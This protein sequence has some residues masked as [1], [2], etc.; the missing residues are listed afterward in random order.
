M[1]F[2]QKEPSHSLSSNALRVLKLKELQKDT[3]NNE[4]I[5]SLSIL[6]QSNN[7][8]TVLR[9]I[10]YDRFFVHYWSGSELNVYRQYIKQ[11]IHSIISIDATGGV[12]Q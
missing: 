4:P 6:K 3:F 9:D 1:K 12:V 5:I 10:G 8:N 11:N 2:G 7:F